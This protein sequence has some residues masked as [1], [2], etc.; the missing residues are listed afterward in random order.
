MRSASSSTRPTR[1]SPVLPY[2]RFWS[3]LR[4]QS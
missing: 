1:L 3:M 2:S 4:F